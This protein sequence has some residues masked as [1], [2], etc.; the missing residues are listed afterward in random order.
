[1]SINDYTYADIADEA[2]SV[3]HGVGFVWATMIWDMYW[4]FIGEYGYDSDIYYGTGGNNMATQLVM[5]GLKLITCGNVGFVEGRN[6]II[7][8][9]A[10]L[11]D[12]V[13][14]CLIRA[15]F[16]RRGVGALAQQGTSESRSDQVP[17]DTVNPLGPCNDLS[18]FDNTK[19][20]SAYI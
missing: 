10:A 5:D 2:L 3:P 8:A 7:Q 16:A 9:D 15:V 18:I 4:A 1:M 12:G 14:E 20:Y 19:P 17:D 13:N 6:S 11:Y